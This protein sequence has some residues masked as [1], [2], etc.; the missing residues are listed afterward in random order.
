MIG[1][2]LFFDYGKNYG[3]IR[4]DDGGAD[5]FVHIKALDHA[6]IQSLQEGD[7]VEFEVDRDPHGRPH[8][9]AVKLVERAKRPINSTRL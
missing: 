4:R 8:A 3:F 2:V 1:R 9:V 5:V 6:G 7:T